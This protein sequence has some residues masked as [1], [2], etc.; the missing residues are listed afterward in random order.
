MGWPVSVLRQRWAAFIGQWSL[1]A[2][3][4]KISLISAELAP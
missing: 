4:P 3:I 2:A 1:M